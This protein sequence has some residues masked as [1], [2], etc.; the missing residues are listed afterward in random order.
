[1]AQVPPNIIV[2]QRRAMQ[3]TSD[4]ARNL[5]REAAQTRM[6]RDQV[7]EIVVRDEFQHLCE[8]LLA[9][10]SVQQLRAF[11]E[12]TGGVLQVEDKEKTCKMMALMLLKDGSESEYLNNIVEH[13]NGARSEVGS[14]RGRG[15]GRGRDRGFRGRGRGRGRGGFRG[16]G[17]G[18]GAAPS[19]DTGY[20]PA[21]APQAETPNRYSLF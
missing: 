14:V 13:G 10:K 20:H 2:A 21:G 5:G 17:Q 7:D 19:L 1:M 12:G 6:S 18:Q 9:E 11:A 3:A 15:R 8:Q 4:I 16:R